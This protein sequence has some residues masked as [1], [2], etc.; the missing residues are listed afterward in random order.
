LYAL[1]LHEQ[2]PKLDQADDTDGGKIYL[3]RM[4]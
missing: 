2:N 4:R 3:S 1:K